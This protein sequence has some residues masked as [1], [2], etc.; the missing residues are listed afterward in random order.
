MK[1]RN[2][3]FGIFSIAFIAMMASCTDV[4]PGYTG[5]K[6]YT[7]GD[8]RG[9]IEEYPTGR[10]AMGY[11]TD[12]YEYPTFVTTYIWTA[13][14]QEG[15]ETD[16]SFT[17]QTK[18]GLSINADVGISIRVKADEGVA[19]KVFQ[20]Y[21]K[22]INQM[23]DTNIRNEVRDALN[24]HA[25]KYSVD[26]VIGVGK[27]Q[28]LNEVES[29]V[30]V[31]FDDIGLEIVSLSWVNS[32]RLPDSVV[33][34]LNAKIEATQVALQRENEVKTAEAEANKRIAEARGKAESILLEAKAQAEANLLLS[35]SMTTTLLQLEW[36]KRWDGKLPTVNSGEGGANII[37]F[38]NLK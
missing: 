9:T 26:E 11:G 30:K 10:Y 1:L 34:A 15:S 17:F 4:K 5:L 8:K 19:T 23:I 29:S 28:L 13:D 20:T 18:E 33:K 22:D 14:K 7:L 31:I 12:W 32:L 35:K 21:R 24:I 25:S 2:F 6:V 16:E 3:V 37:D 36:I 27:A 38:S